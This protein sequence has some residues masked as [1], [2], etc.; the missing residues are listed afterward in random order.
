MSHSSKHTILLSL[1]K[2]RIY[3]WW[4]FTSDI[5]KTLKG[6]PIIYNYGPYLHVLRK[7]KSLNVLFI[8]VKLNLIASIWFQS[9]IFGLI[10]SIP[11]FED[12]KMCCI[13]VMLCPGILFYYILLYTV[14]ALAVKFCIF[15]AFFAAHSTSSCV[16]A[17]CS[18][19]A[20][21]ST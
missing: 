11:S 18:S 8:A 15:K 20:V 21:G 4:L 7:K 19:S 12:Y 17:W 10:S 16:V 9:F 13:L 6:L 14:S 2:I 5:K 1:I 3:S